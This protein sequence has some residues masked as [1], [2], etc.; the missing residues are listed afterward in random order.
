MGTAVGAFALQRYGL[1]SWFLGPQFQTAKNSKRH[2][3]QVGVAYLFYLPDIDADDKFIEKVIKTDYGPMRVPTKERAL[4]DYMRHLDVF[5]LSYFVDGL[6][7]YLEE[8]GG[9]TKLLE[10]A[11]HYGIRDEMQKWIDEDKNYANW[12]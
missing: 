2:R 4:C 10:V 12:G 7:D 8:E 5:E 9:S 6:H 1:V 11:D 3:T